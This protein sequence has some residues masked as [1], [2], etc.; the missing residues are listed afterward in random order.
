VAALLTAVLD[1]SLREQVGFSAIVSTGSMLDVDWGDLIS[2]FGEDPETKKHSS[3]H[4]IG[5]RRTLL[6]FRRTR[7][8]V[9]QANYRDQGRPDRSRLEGCFIAHGRHDGQR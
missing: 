8:C 2:F 9:E 3:L 7:S 4:R 6:S 1:W 5:C